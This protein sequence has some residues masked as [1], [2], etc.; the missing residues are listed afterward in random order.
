MSRVEPLVLR[1]GDEHRLREWTRSSTISAGLAQRA[2]IV[3]LAAEGTSSAEVGR[4]V[5]V[6]LPT[7]HSRAG[8][9]AKKSPTMID[10]GHPACAT[11]R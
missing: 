9:N 6:S 4:R 7:V 10:T 5:G 8:G 1:A 3:L 11:T 2:R